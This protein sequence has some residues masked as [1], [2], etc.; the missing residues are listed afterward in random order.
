MPHYSE[1]GNWLPIHWS[2]EG[3]IVAAQEM[4]SF[5]LEAGLCHFPEKIGL[6]FL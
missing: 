2:S 3:E 1:Y 4:F 5:I 6:L